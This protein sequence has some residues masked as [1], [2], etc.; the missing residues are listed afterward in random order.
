MALF[1]ISTSFYVIHHLLCDSPYFLWFTIYLLEKTLLEKTCLAKEPQFY[2]SVP[3][4]IAKLH[5]YKP[6]K[7]PVN[8]LWFSIYYN[9]QWQPCSTPKY[10][11]VSYMG[12]NYLCLTIV[13]AEYCIE[14]FNTVFS[15]HNC[16]THISITEFHYLYLISGDIHF[17]KFK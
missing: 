10:I 6:M 7:T 11:Y 5:A 13:H 14:T 12:K 1:P 8:D 17:I 9:S 3:C 15:M 16:E 2:P 4:I